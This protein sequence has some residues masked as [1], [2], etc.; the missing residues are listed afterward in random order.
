MTSSDSFS[1][2]VLLEKLRDHFSSTSS[3]DIVLRAEKLVQSESQSDSDESLS[4]LATEVS[5][6]L[7]ERDRPL[8]S[9]AFQALASLALL[10]FSKLD[11][12][13]AFLRDPLSVS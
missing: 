12:A 6:Y 2:E 9:D 5:W 1:P 3:R 4:E 10:L 13:Q 7:K 11:A 8:S